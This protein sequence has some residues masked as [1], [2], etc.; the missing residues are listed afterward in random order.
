MTSIQ[1]NAGGIPKTS[2][3]D[4]PGGIL[5]TQFCLSMFLMAALD[6]IKSHRLA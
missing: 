3:S 4:S 6:A 1:D 2:L 5:W